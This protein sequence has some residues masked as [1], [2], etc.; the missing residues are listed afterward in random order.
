MRTA[1]SLFATS[2]LASVLITPSCGLQ[3]ERSGDEQTTT[4]EIT[5]GTTYTL[6]AA[7]SQK[8]VDVAGVSTADGANVHQWTC[9]GRANQQWKARNVGGGNW[10]LTSVNSGKCLEVAG[11]STANGGNVDQSACQGTANQ[12][13]TLVTVNGGPADQFQIKSVSSGECLDVAGVSTADGA[14]IQQWTCG[15]NT[16]QRFTF[17]SISGGGGNG[18]GGSSGGGGTSGTGCDSPN[19]VWK[20]GNKTNYTSY[21]D[22]GSEECIKFS[23]CEFE[24]LFASCNDKKPK[25]WVMS[26]NIVAAFPSFAALNLHDL[27]LRSGSKSI[28]V[29]VFDTCGDADCDGCCTQN[30]GNADALIDIESF[31]DARWGVPD[32][33]IQWADLGPTRTTG[34][35]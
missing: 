8:C 25:S 33:P 14:N 22:P 13:W 34:C 28:V 27:C 32:G 18:G 23:G 24:G 29:T 35:Q 15:A 1:Q 10:E 11:G 6:K 30:R 20:T 31:T 17:N 21:P 12:R 7:H 3:T 4:G 2:A 16:N 19:L 9:H 26:H 5:S